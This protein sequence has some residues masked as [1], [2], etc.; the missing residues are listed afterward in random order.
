MNLLAAGVHDVAGVDLAATPV[1]RF[2][3]Y[4]NPSL[5]QDRLGLIATRGHSREFEQLPEPDHVSADRDLLVGHRVVVPAT[6][7]QRRMLLP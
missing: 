1:L 4:A 5:R 2:T 6:S 7:V 3:V